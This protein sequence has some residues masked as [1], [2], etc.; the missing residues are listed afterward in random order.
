MLADA[1]TPLRVGRAAEVP[2]GAAQVA[3]EAAVMSARYGPRTRVGQRVV[4]SRTSKTRKFGITRNFRVLGVVGRGFAA[5]TPGAGLRGR[6]RHRYPLGIAGRF[7]PAER[8]A[9]WRYLPPGHPLEI[10][11]SSRHAGPDHTSPYLLVIVPE[12]LQ[13]LVVQVAEVDFHL[14]HH[15]CPI[16]NGGEMEPPLDPADPVRED[17]VRDPG[18]DTRRVARHNDGV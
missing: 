5:R 7:T 12:S 17:R 8:P 13:H 16:T 6:R 11:E 9:T 18:E 4:P 1:S 15:A 14:V 10:L 3:G 2:F